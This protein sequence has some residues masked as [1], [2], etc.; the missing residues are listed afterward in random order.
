[1]GSEWNGGSAT[2]V[3][4]AGGR[5]TTTTCNGMAVKQLVH[6]TQLAYNQCL[7]CLQLIRHAKKLKKKHA[8]LVNEQTPN[9]KKYYTYTTI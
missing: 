1:M 5:Y 9:S 8:L 7:T 2:V 3:V 6:V 4:I